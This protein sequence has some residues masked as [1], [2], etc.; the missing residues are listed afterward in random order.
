MIFGEPISFAEALRRTVARR[1]MPTNLGTAELRQLGQSVLEKSLFSARTTME[2]Y[3]EEVKGQVM[4]LVEGKVDPATARL[5]L[6]ES[7]KGLG[8][9][10]DPDKRGGI[11]DL[12]SDRRI[13]LVI[14]TNTEMAQGFGY[15]RQGQD[16]SILDQWP[17]LELF[18]AEA[19]NQERNWQQRWMIA[20]QSTGTR[21]GDGWTVTG[22]GRLVA[23]K[24][25][26]IWDQLGA[27]E[28]F[29]DG[30]GNPY[31]PFA[32]SSGMDVR[33]VSREDAMAMGLIDRD[34]RIAPRV[35]AFFEQERTE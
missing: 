17:A 5:R 34:T 26:A 9:E 4:Q 7:L 29:D 30:I 16:E 10:P 35:N 23:L 6:K 20:G 14:Q 25:H 18:R 1:V 2:P 3:L 33:D 11:E 28:L 31:P 22:D 21:I 8:Y 32:F 27:P 19:R 15:D 13:E 12:S 24:N